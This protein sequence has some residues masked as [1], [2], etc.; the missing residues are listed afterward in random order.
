M[1]N[2]LLLTSTIALYFMVASVVQAASVSLN[3]D[4]LVQNPGDVFTLDLMMDF[5]GDA[6]LGG[7]IDIFYDADAISFLSFD[8]STSTLNL[9][10]AFSRLPD[11]QPGVL[12]GL[13][14]GHFDGVSGPGVVGTLSFE[15]MNFGEVDMIV[16]NTDDNFVGSFVSAIDYEDMTSRIVFTGTHVTIVPLPA[17]AWLFSGGLILLLVFNKRRL[18]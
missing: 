4:A 13:A 12:S 5:S 8:F 18:K 7:G 17:A 1:K 10:P 6:T 9:D 14:F 3:P 15:A 16:S 11:E 2:K